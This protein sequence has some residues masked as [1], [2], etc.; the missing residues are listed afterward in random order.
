[1][2]SDP[3]LSPQFQPEDVPDVSLRPKY[4]SDFTGQREICSNLKVFIE[5]A[6]K[7]GEAM[8]H[9]LFFGPPGLG[10]TTLAQIIASELGVGFRS[11]SGPIISKAGDL[12]AILTNLQP[13]DVLFIDEIHRLNPAVEEILYPAMEDFRLDLIIGEG[14]AARSIQIDLP[15]FTLVA[16]TTRT[17]LISSPLRDRFGIPLRLNYYTP[18]ELEQIVER[19]ARLLGLSMAKQALL[20]IASRARG[21]PRIAGRLLRRIRDF[22]A[23]SNVDVITQYVADQALTRLGIDKNGLDAQDNLYLKSMATVYGGGPVGAE[24]LAAILCEQK[25]TLEE[26]IEPYLLQKKL[27]QRTQRGRILTQAGYEYLGLTPIKDDAELV[28]SSPEK[29]DQ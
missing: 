28:W 6:R 3:V 23:V 12:A 1:M 21:T 8:D 19:G 24:T 25:D 7:R 20:E 22:A 11:T 13:H 10:K 27:I 29:S 18:D 15:P 5:A 2:A 16:A 17:G 4:L 26:V 14:P 9:V